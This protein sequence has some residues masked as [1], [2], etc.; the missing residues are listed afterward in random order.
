MGLQATSPPTSPLHRPHMP[1]P[2]PMNTAPMLKRKHDLVEDDEDVLMSVTTGSGV[3]KIC[4]E[5]VCG[6][7]NVNNEH[8]NDVQL[9]HRHHANANSDEDL[10]DF[11]DDETNTSSDDDDSGTMTDEV[12]CCCNC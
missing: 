7:G 12:C 5:V 3:K 2:T 1:V 10:E 11:S 6:S 9:H 4:V 8:V